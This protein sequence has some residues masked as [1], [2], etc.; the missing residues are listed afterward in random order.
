MQKE[1]KKQHKIYLKLFILFFQE[2][3][4]VILTIHSIVIPQNIV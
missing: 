4:K 2:K 3:K 1:K